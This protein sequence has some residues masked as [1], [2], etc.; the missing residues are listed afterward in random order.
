MDFVTRYGK[1]RD[2]IKEN[3][4]VKVDIL[5]KI[6]EFENE[7][8]ENEK[9]FVKA[10]IFTISCHKSEKIYGEDQN[11]VFNVFKQNIGLLFTNDKNHSVKELQNDVN[12]YSLNN[13]VYYINTHYSLKDP[14]KREAKI[15]QIISES[16]YEKY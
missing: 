6:K 4:L 9:N 1:L 2:F 13:F 16:N 11:D 15:K 5:D 3:K 14:K 12:K 7:I 8:N 10:G